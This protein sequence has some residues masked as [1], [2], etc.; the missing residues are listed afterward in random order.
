[1]AQKLTPGLLLVLVVVTACVVDCKV[2]YILPASV[3]N[4]KPVHVLEVQMG[5]QI[6]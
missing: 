3:P 4:S 1:M 2:R 6:L 5:H